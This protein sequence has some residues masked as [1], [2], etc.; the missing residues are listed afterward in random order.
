MRRMLRP[1]RLGA[2]G[3]CLLLMVG[4]MAAPSAAGA[5]GGERSWMDSSLR[6]EARAERL[7]RR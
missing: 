3:T 2:V 4:V 5:A 6:P 1:I 7:R